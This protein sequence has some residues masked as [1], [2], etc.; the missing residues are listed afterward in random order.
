M[1]DFAGLEKAKRQLSAFC[2]RPYESGWLFVGESGTGKTSAGLALAS[3][4]AGEL[5][6]IPSRECDLE[7]VSRVRRA[8]Q[9]VPAIGYQWHVILCDEADRMT[10]AA[11]DAF[12][13][14]LD[15]T[16][17]PPRTVFVFTANDTE[18]LHPRVRSRLRREDFCNYGI[19]TF[20]AS[21][22]ERVWDA[23]APRETA[24]P[25]FARMVK[26]TNGN[27]RAALMELETELLYSL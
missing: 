4:I 17:Q 24:R 8:C 5:T 22:L 20:A 26:E 14:L 21:L 7:R 15:G 25:N 9:Y 23:E 13:S 10:D 2:S 27:V 16:N 1:A 12:L 18:R 11:Q 6:H 3:A 19:Q